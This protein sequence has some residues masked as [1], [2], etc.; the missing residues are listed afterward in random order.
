MLPLLRYHLVSWR[1]QDD[2]YDIH[3]FVQIATRVSLAQT[4]VLHKSRGQALTA[5]EA[6]LPS[7]TFESR[8][9][10]ATIGP[11]ASE[12]LQC[13]FGGREELLRLA[14]VSLSMALYWKFEASFFKAKDAVTR[15]IEIR[16][17]LLGLDDPETLEAQYY[18]I[19]VLTHLGNSRESEPAVRK[20]ITKVEEVA[21]E[22]I[23]ISPDTHAWI[24]GLYDCL[25]QALFIKGNFEESKHWFQEALERYKLAGPPE[26]PGRLV[27]VHNLIT[28]LTRRCAFDEAE[29]RCKSALQE[30]L[31][32]FGK[33]DVNVIEFRGLLGQI[34]ADTSRYEDA[35][36]LLA[37]ARL[38][39]IKIFGKSHS[40]SL[41]A[42]HE[43]VL[44]L[45]KQHK[46]DKALEEIA[47]TLPQ[48]ESIYGPLHHNT[49]SILS[50]KGTVLNQLDRYEEALDIHSRVLMLRKQ[51]L[52]ERHPSTLLSTH[53]L[54]VSHIKLGP[55]HLTIGSSLIEQV[56]TI[57]REVHNPNHTIVIV[58]MYD[59]AD[60]LNRQ[61]KIQKAIEQQKLCLKV[62][63]DGRNHRIYL[64]G[65]ITFR[66]G[67]YLYAFGQY[68]ETLKHFRDAAQ[69]F[70]SRDPDQHGINA[71]IQS[72]ISNALEKLE[73]F[74]EAEG[75]LRDT[76]SGLD[77]TL[78]PEHEDTLSRVC[79]LADYLRRRSKF[80]EAE[81]IY[82][83]LLAIYEKLFGPDDVQIFRVL[84]QRA[85]LY[86]SQGKASLAEAEDREIL[87]K[88]QRLFQRTV[89][90]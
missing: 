53:Q 9:F 80:D 32:F 82:Q 43:F 79:D 52:G 87:Q 59:R 18:R 1:P 30:T 8:N 13:D 78:G 5:L 17:T 45:Y 75:V 22:E 34:Y 72:Q 86:R 56:L 3:H 85:I 77:A 70:L 11:H 19:Q 29:S 14:S 84:N 37:D 71:F 49:L 46:Y 39:L 7:L 89:V 15:A 40:K 69:F 54:A 25:G 64:I 16:S 90:V 57:G 68:E 61:G 42:N 20:L 26:R 73:H 48:V 12:V 21:K 28:L 36:S 44:L 76:T 62:A 81:T 35:L 41:L 2:S 88:R 63:T 27:V 4:S 38:Q 6:V 66:L 67:R 24:A 50:L 60:V 55:T 31:E 51:A 74:T 65:D 10:Y 23:Y 58:A 47:D 83:S 33:D